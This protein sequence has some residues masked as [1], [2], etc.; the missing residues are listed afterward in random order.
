M[1]VPRKEEFKFT[2]EKFASAKAGSP[3]VKRHQGTNIETKMRSKVAAP[4]ATP[5]QSILVTMNV[6]LLQ[7]SG[8][9]PIETGPLSW[10]TMPFTFIDRLIKLASIDV[11]SG[12]SL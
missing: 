5:I 2:G 9:L 11:A 6:H 8:M 7:F 4:L 12:C 3:T 1:G 10:I